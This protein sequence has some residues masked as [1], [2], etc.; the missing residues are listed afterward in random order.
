MAFQT[1][2]DTCMVSNVA[3][4]SNTSAYLSV[5]TAEL[6][7]SDDTVFTTVTVETTEILPQDTTRKYKP[8]PTTPSG[9]Q[10]AYA[11]LYH[12]ALIQTIHVP[13]QVAVPA[14]DTTDKMQTSLDDVMK[15]RP[16]LAAL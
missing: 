15:T 2:V 7:S 12:G 8:V 5:T 16:S 13:K 14:T 10:P 4:N 11:H 1:R 6:N 3:G 9:Y